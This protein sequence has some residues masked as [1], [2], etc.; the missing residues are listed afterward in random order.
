[1]SKPTDLRPPACLILDDHPVVR[2]GLRA[3]IEATWQQAQVSDA[4]SLA[5]A[6][7]TA[8]GRD[9]DV[10]IVDPWKAGADVGELVAT[11]SKEVGAPIVVFTADGGARLLSEAL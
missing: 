2:Q 9:L 1:M 7:E 8:A 4:D 6:I 10:V 5:G 11:L 3:L